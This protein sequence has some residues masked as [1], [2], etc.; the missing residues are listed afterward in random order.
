MLGMKTGQPLYVVGTSTFGTTGGYL[1]PGLMM[2][3]LQ[4]GWVAVIGAV[5]ADFIMKG[6]GQTSRTLFSVIAV[7]WIYSLGWVAIK[8]IHYVARVA[9]Y[10][11]WVPLIMVIIV[12]WA[13]KGGIAHYQAPHPDQTTGFLNVLTVVIGYFAT[14]GAAGADFGMNNANKKDVVLGGIFGIVVGVLIA[15]GLPILAVA[16]YLG[17]GGQGYD[18]SAAIA[19]VGALAPDHVLPLRR[20]LACAQ[21][22]LVVHRVEQLQ[23]HAAEDSPYCLHAC[24][25]HPQR[26]PRRHRRRQQSGRFLQHR[27]RIV[28]SHLRRDDR[29]LPACGQAM[30][31]AE[32]W[33]STGPAASHGRSAS[34]SASRST[35][36]DSRQPG[37]TPTTPLASIR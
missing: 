18:Y 22:L 17:N 34:W 19:S 21:L 28:R 13:N 33:A 6:L 3:F 2:G 23:H 26:H 8:G 15:G 16:G 29:R 10:L 25:S 5:A 37:S 27:G 31:R 24:R 9:K 4:V 1:I 35:S 36:P 30:V 11:N 14:A 7:V 20:R 12:F 32:S